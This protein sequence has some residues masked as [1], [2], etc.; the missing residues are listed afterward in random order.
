ME[1][2]F[3][4]KLQKN[5][6][7]YQLLVD[8]PDTEDIDYGVLEEACKFFIQNRQF[9]REQLVFQYYMHNLMKRRF[10]EIYEHYDLYFR[11]YEGALLVYPYYQLKQEEL[12]LTETQK[13]IVN[14][15]I[16]YSLENKKEWGNPKVKSKMEKA[17][18]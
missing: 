18:R 10:Q 16:R 2:R 3:R 13:A 8:Y 7:T 1:K 5:H 12:G 14:E 15:M 17:L 11:E 9:K 6:K 4:Y